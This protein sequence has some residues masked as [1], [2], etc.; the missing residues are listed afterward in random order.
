MIP[1][2]ESFF[3]KRSLI[4][5]DPPEHTNLRKLVNRAFTNSAMSQLEPRIREITRGLVDRIVE[6]GNEFDLI[7]DLAIPLPVTIIAEMLGV[8]AEHRQDFKRWSDAITGARASLLMQ[9]GDARKAHEARVLKSCQEFIAY[10][11]EAIE[12][13][14]REPQNDLISVLVTAEKNALLDPTELINLTRLLLIAG[15]ETTTNLLGNT[16]LA[17]LKFPSELEKVCEN[18]GL[19]P[20]LVEEALRYDGPV[21]GLFRRVTQ[22]VEIAGT[23][24]PKG[25]VVM[26]LYASANHD[27]RKFRD[28]ETFNI[29][30]DTG[31]HLAFGQGIHFC[32][33]A[34]LA[35]LEARI[36][37]GE[38]FSRLTDFELLGSETRQVDSFSLRGVTKLPL[39]FRSKRNPSQPIVSGTS[40]KGLPCLAVP[41]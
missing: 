18:A 13:K 41:N 3:E 40:D 9:E 38:L 1:G 37:L 31:G 15:N 10:F 29:L 34:P 16:L 30:R 32:V 4:G 20:N 22:D 25:G 12:K 33:G 2:M 6:K 23:L 27:E 26:P 28:P 19:I 8:D 21:I 14:R 17:L 39:S 5:S 24:I 7:E 11:S 36:A 35:R